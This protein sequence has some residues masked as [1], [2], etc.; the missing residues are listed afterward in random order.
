MTVFYAGVPETITDPDGSQEGWFFTD[1]GGVVVCQPMGCQGVFPSNN[2]P[3]DKATFDETI[4]V[5]KGMTGIGNGTLVSDDTA[6]G[7]ATWRWTQAEPISTYLTTATVGNYTLAQSVDPA[8]HLVYDFTDTSAN[9]TRPP[10]TPVQLTGLQ[11]IL[12]READTVDFLS[13]IYGPYPF[14]SYGSIVTNARNVGYALEVATK[15][16]YPSAPGDVYTHTHELLHQWIGDSVTYRQI[17]DM[18]IHEG[19]ATWIEWYW[20]NQRDGG[21][22]TAEMFDGVDDDPAFDWSLPP[23]L[24]AADTLFTEPVYNRGALTYEGLR[25]IIGD[26]AY[27]DFLRTMYERFQYGA[28]TTADVMAVAEEVSGRDLDQFFADY[29]YTPGQPPRPSTYGAAPAADASRAEP[30]VRHVGEQ[31]ADDPRPDPARAG[32]R[33]PSR[34]RGGGRARRSRAGLE[35]VEQ[36]HQLVRAADLEEV[37]AGARARVSAIERLGDDEVAGGEMQA[38]RGSRSWVRLPVEVQRDVGAGEHVAQLVAVQA[39]RVV[40][41]VVLVLGVD[42]EALAMIGRVPTKRIRGGAALGAT[43][44][45]GGRRRAAAGAPHA[46]VAVGG[47]GR[48]AGRRRRPGRSS[49]DR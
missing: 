47:R 22:T 3:Y 39:V 15:P 24:P 19:M 20:G 4:V 30:N 44:A 11:A 28:I 49:P 46:R 36:R 1:T 12:A 37:D 42:Q 27:F 9:G 43:G 18:W 13:G 34:G 48:R 14:G 6:N 10:F 26:A 23:A 32:S 16:F 17:Q 40:Q 31:V 7:Q 33:R 8:G 35:L 45:T 21:P 29:L 38:A 41:D 25:Q 2:V 5:P